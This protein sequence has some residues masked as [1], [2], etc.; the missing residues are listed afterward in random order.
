M[1]TPARAA[2]ILIV[3]GWSVLFL[4]I[5]VPFVESAM[6]I[7]A[8]TSPASMPANKST[9]LVG[10][11]VLEGPAGLAAQSAA[12]N[13]TIATQRQY[14]LRAFLIDPPPTFT[15]LPPLIATSDRNGRSRWRAP[16]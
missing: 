12:G 6:I 14:C 1:G 13:N 15:I 8:S 10:G 16:P 11:A 2:G 9:V 5:T 3:R 4:S 7:T